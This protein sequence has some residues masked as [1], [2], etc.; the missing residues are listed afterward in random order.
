MVVV[1]DD[2]SEMAFELLVRRNDSFGQVAAVVPLDEVGNDLSVGLRAEAVALGLERIL[3]LAE[4]LHDPVQDDRDLLVVAAGKRVRV[5]LGDAAVGGPARV[6]EAGPRG[7]AVVAG[8]LL[9]GLEVADR[10]NVLQP[11]VL[12]E[13]EPGRVVAAVFEPLETAEEEMLRLPPPDISDD[14]AHLKLS[15]RSA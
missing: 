10:P 13:C 3:E 9:Q 4:V 2:E 6:A 14:P 11:F 8:H 5:L 7:R 15:L 12:E 1:D